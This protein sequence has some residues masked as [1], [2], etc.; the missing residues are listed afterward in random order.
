MTYPSLGIQNTSGF[1]TIATPISSEESGSL[2]PQVGC[3]LAASQSMEINFLPSFIPAYQN[4]TFH[5]MVGSTGFGVKQYRSNIFYFC[6]LDKLHI[7]LGSQ[8][9]DLSSVK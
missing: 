3:G 4:P 1:S 9:P 7:V 5:Y 8:N 2:D 6:G